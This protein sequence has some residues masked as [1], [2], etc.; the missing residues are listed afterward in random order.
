MKETRGERA[1][2]GSIEIT[3]EYHNGDEAMLKAKR[4]PSSTDGV[5]GVSA[6]P[7]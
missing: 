3:F 4:Y 1:G 7:N 6:E 2:G 5:I